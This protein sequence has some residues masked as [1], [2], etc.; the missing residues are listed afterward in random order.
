MTLTEMINNGS[1]AA[2]IGSHLDAL[3]GDERWR[4]VSVLGRKLQRSLFQTVAH[5]DPLDIDFFVPSEV[6][7]LV[8]IRHRGRNTLPV[9]IDKVR[10]FAKVFC[11]PEDKSSRLFGYN[12]APTGALIG[13][14]YFVAIKAQTSWQERGS[15]VV[16]YWQTPEGPV[17]DGWPKV[18]PNSK[19]LQR[20]VY[21][22]TRDFMRRVSQHVSIGAAYKNNTPLDHYFVLCRQD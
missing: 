9:P 19:G 14:G 22:H 13:P 15:V 11:R 2:E 20:L 8:P 3:N 7:P 16:D 10:F 6:E 4:E 21:F 18:V 17:A 5:T 12:D 1:N